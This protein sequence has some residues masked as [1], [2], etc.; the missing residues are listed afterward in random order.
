MTGNW[1]DFDELE[2]SLSLGELFVIL[3]A[4]R[5]KIHADRKFFAAIQGIDL[6]K[7]AAPPPQLEAM[8]DRIRARLNKEKDNTPAN[9]ITRLK[10]K[11]A[12]KAGFGIGMGLSYEVIGADG[13]ITKG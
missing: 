13:T 5:K 2:S 12:Q 1:R 4:Y 3:D 10:G 11:A 8:A 9:D 7:G 6:D